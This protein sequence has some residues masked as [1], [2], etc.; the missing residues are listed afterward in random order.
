MSFSMHISLRCPLIILVFWRRFLWLILAFVNKCL[1]K[2]RLP[3]FK[4]ALISTFIISENMDISFGY[5]NRNHILKTSEKISCVECRSVHTHTWYPF[6]QRLIIQTFA[7]ES[8]IELDHYIDHLRVE[9]YH[10]TDLLTE[11]CM[12]MFNRNL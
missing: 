3:Q 5:C 7:V 2:W 10:N 9:N 12:F 6:Y 11:L 8:W 1:F 4:I